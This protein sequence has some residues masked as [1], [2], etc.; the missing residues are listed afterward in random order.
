MRTFR[1]ATGYKVKGYYPDNEACLIS[2]S[3]NVALQEKGI[4]EQ[5]EQTDSANTI[6]HGSAGEC[7]T[8]I[9]RTKMQIIILED[10]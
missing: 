3:L 1:L 10:K 7:E 5:V 6:S 2:E 4:G 8:N 9:A